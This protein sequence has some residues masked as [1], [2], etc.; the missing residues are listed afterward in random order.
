MS[1]K[2]LSCSTPE[3]DQRAL[4]ELRLVVSK[5]E[6]DY[7]MRQYEQM[8]PS[9]WNADSLQNITLMPNQ[10]IKQVLGNRGV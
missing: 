1:T 7:L 4:E 2:C 9:T 8:P 5:Q 3:D 6:V 10:T